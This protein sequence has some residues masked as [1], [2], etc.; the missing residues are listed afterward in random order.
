MER[1][2]SEMTYNVLMG[3][4]KSVKPYSLT[5]SLTIICILTVTNNG[6]FNVVSS[7]V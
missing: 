4:L 7:I 2:V 3:T 1:L 6:W 5:D